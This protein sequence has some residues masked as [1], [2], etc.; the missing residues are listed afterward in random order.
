MENISNPNLTWTTSTN[1]TDRGGQNCEEWEDAQHVLFQIAN[2]CFAVAFL[3]PPKFRLS[4]L[5]MRGVLTIGF[6]FVTLWAGVNVC[7]PDIFAWNVTFMLTNFFHTIFLAYINIPPRVHPELLE[8]YNKVFTPLKVDKKNFKDLV[9]CAE[10]LSLKPGE[11]YGT[12]GMT[13]ADEQLSILL[14]G[15]MKATCE[16]V[17]LHYL[18]PNEFIDS[19]EWEAC[20]LDS[21]RLFQVTLS[22]IEPCRY[23]RWPRR[24]L[25]LFLNNNPFMRV[26]LHNLIGKDITHKLYSLNEYHRPQGKRVRSPSASDWWRHQIPRSFSVDAVHTGTKGHMRSL[27]WASRDRRTSTA[28]SDSIGSTS[29]NVTIVLPLCTPMHKTSV[30]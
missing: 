30:A 22:A 16:D 8:L 1:K 29:S 11:H 7:A 12:E 6:L 15:K 5:L 27:L 14:S 26:I 18:Q 21:D 10:I 28:P 24:E 13:V 3:V 9:S 19:P 17:L 20:T 25:E 4:I 23:I 2:L